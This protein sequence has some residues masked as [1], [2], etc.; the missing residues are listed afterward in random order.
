MIGCDRH[1]FCPQRGQSFLFAAVVAGQLPVIRF[2]LE[3][4]EHYDIEQRDAGG[5]SLLHA[6]AHHGHKE[7]TQVLLEAGCD[8]TTTDQVSSS[9]SAQSDTHQ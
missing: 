8:V 6:A 4:L 9:E 7:I 3:N 1:P 5:R 2:V